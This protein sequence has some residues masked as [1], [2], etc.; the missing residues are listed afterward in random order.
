MQLFSNN[1]RKEPDIIQC[2]I[3]TSLVS[4]VE[5]LTLLRILILFISDDDSDLEYSSPGFPLQ[6]NFFQFWRTFLLSAVN[7]AKMWNP[8]NTFSMVN[9]YWNTM[10]AAWIVKNP[11]RHVNPA[12]QIVHK[13]TNNKKHTS[14]IL[15]LQTDYFEP[16]FDGFSCILIPLW[17]I[18]CMTYTYW[19]SWG[20]PSYF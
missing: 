5:L 3:G 17:R 15:K 20:W 4:L 9:I 8:W 10:L 7:K 2:L 11:N 19:I 6:H 14:N 16:K 1:Y 12:N 18:W 13:V